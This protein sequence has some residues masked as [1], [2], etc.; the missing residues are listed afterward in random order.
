MLQIPELLAPAGDLERLRYAINYGA[1]AVYCALPEFGMR[2]APTN[3]TPEQLSEGVI[4]AH[5]RGRKVYLTMNTLPTNEEADRLPQAIKDAAAAGVDAFIVADLGVLDACKTFAPD[6]DVHMSTQTGIT[7]W[8]AARAAYNM[9]AKRVVLAREMTLQ[10]IAT[11]RDKTPPEL[12]I[13]AFVHGAMCM[14]VSGRCL[15]SN[16][17]AGRDANRGQCA[18][19]CRW[20]Y[21]LSEET[22]PGQL[23]EIGE[24]ENGSYILNAKDMC[25]IEHLDKVIDA[26]VTSL[27]IEGRAKSFYYVAVITN[28]Y[29]QAVDLYRKDPQHFVLPSWLEEE[30]RKVSHRQ[31]STGFY[32]GRPEQ[33]QYYENA[34]YVRQWD[35]VA[36]VDKTEGDILYCTQRNK[37]SL[38]E[39]VEIICPHST[40]EDRPL[41]YTVTS[42]TDE[43]GNPR[44]SANNAMMKLTMPA[45]GLVLE[46]GSI[47]RRAAEQ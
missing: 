4:Y 26:G 10:D 36:V 24:N 44:E 28:A 8:A 45:K 16:Y 33:G 7:N 17:M 15:L 35:V 37:F 40:V 18:Q 29:R 22:R 14:S 12:E 47:I 2:S 41:S 46:A 13:E 6:I 9:G 11:L 31:Y 27:K 1:D 39:T 20:K 32:F 30:T 23:Y 42:I 3:F 21:Y 38:G 5:A 43:Q 19:P 34:G 25:M